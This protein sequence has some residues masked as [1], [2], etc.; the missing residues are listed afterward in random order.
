M[1]MPE[2]PD[3]NDLEA[4][5][6]APIEDLDDVNLRDYE[7]VVFEN[8]QE[9]DGE[10][11]PEQRESLIQ[12]NDQITE[13]VEAARDNPELLDPLIEILEDGRNDLLEMRLQRL[14]DER[15]SIEEFLTDQLNPDDTQDEEADEE[16]DNDERGSIED[17]LRDQLNLDDTQDEEA[18]E[19]SLQLE[20]RHGRR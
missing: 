20:R 9:D 12:L 3:S 1:K 17:Y 6:T 14:R 19:D 15:G 11:I 4:E 13:L 5:S 8:T 10:I 2:V 16:D 18:D 7:A